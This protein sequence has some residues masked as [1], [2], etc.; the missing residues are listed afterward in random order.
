[1]RYPAL[2]SLRG[3]AALIVVIHHH[4]LT[5]PE[6]YPYLVGATGLV[7]WLMYS[8]L[9]LIWAGG[10]AV[11]FFFLLSGF[12]LSLGVWRGTQLDMQ[13]FIVR[14]IW[15]IWLPF[16][17]AVTLAWA[18]ALLM[19]HEPLPQVS[20]W[21]NTIW[22]SADS[23][24]YLQHV[25]M[26]GKMD[27]LN[28]SFIPVVWSLKW[29]MWLS[30]L[31]PLVLLVAR[32]STLLVFTACLTFLALYYGPNYG[33]GD[34]ASNLTRYFPMFIVGAWLSRH[35][36]AIAGFVQGLSSSVRVSALVFALLL[37]PVQWYGWNG[38]TPRF[39]LLGG[40]LGVM[41]ASS[42]LIA[43]ALGWGRW[44]SWLERPLLTWLGRISFSLYLYHSLVLTV[45]VRA[46]TP[47]LPLPALLLISFLLTFVVAHLAWK[48]VELPA[49]AQGKK[50]S[51]G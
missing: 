20:S 17:V 23:S 18:L 51:S 2:E 32:Q 24:S 48:W 38:S 42:V 43:L 31:L 9:H 41:I 50:M 22:Q 47:W 34:T 46:G 49:I 13:L 45:V 11:I 8:P 36:E 29:E 3:I 15:R 39:Q 7:G 30:L 16:M 4:L 40:D 12:V 44:R 6:I 5:F 14:R 1:M 25:L 33:D 37:F 19:G 10:E 26:L 27:S 28:H 35:R 21:F